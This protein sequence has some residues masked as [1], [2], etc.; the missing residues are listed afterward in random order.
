MSKS[1]KCP[2]CGCEKHY[3]ISSVGDVKD[4]SL[5]GFC[6][7][8]LATEGYVECEA[9]F[10]A[11]V[12]KNCGH[13]DLFAED[14]KNALNMKENELQKQIDSLEQLLKNRKD[15]YEKIHL[16]IEPI[17]KEINDIKAG[18]KDEEKTVKEH[19]QLIEKLQKLE[20]GKYLDYKKQEQNILKQINDLN[21][22]LEEM[23]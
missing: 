10:D 4:L 6:S 2:I 11:F 5:I 15:E 18:L 3:Q 7:C 20:N 8:V 14:I 19:N 13:V 21:E 9:H 23:R 22:A 1:F 12:C 17:Q 16:L